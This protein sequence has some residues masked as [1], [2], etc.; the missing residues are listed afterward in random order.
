MPTKHFI[1]AA[2][3]AAIVVVLVVAITSLAGGTTYREAS[4]TSDGMAYEVNADAA[5]IL[6]ISDYDAKEIWQLQPSTSAY[7]KYHN[8]PPPS[9]ASPDSS[10]NIWFTDWRTTTGRINVLLQTVTTWTIEPG[11]LGGLAF[12]DTNRLWIATRSSPPTGAAVYRFDPQSTQLCGYEW[13]GGSNSEYVLYTDGYVWLADK[14]G[15]RII[16]F[17]PAAAQDQVKWWSLA[18]GA[19]PRGLALDAAGQLWWAD[20][21][22]DALASL[23][24]DNN[25]VTTYSLSPGTLP[26]M[27]IFVDGRVWYTT[28]SGSVG[29][30]NPALA[31]GTTATAATGSLTTTSASCR[32]IG[33]GAT[34]AASSAQ[35]TLAWGASSE[36]APVV[37]ADGWTIYQL[38]DGA[39]LYGI[40]QSS[41]SLWVADSGR[42]K[43]VRLGDGKPLRV[44]LPLLVR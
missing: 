27:L 3:I 18:P 7:T 42:Q 4:L 11:A 26:E 43:L 15:R 12:D 34:T 14:Y 40:A 10:G 16:R 17:E 38:P 24:P 33:T 28:I 20:L 37:D 30:L 5:G 1:L 23:N 39:D 44:F 19:A 21:G 41:G 32:S 13:Q 36:L 8:L 35:G 22:A 9:D 31:S 2:G 25:Q 29:A 6:F